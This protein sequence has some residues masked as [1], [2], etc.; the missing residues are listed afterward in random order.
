MVEDEKVNLEKVEALVKFFD[1][2]TKTIRIEK[3]IWCANSMGL[4]A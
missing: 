4:E 3:F 1:A 2:L